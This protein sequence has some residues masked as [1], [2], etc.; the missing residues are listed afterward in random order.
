MYNEITFFGSDWQAIKLVAAFNQSIDEGLYPHMDFSQSTYIN[1]DTSLKV[2]CTKHNQY[3]RSELRHIRSGKRTGCRQ[4][5]IEKR[6]ERIANDYEQRCL[7]MSAWIPLE[8]WVGGKTPIKHKC[9]CCGDVQTFLPITPLSSIKKCKGAISDKESKTWMGEDVKKLTQKQLNKS[10]K[11]KSARYIKKGK[12]DFDSFL[13]ENT[14]VTRV[15]KYKGMM[16]KCKFLCSVCNKTHKRRC[17]DLKDRVLPSTNS[18][19]CKLC[20]FMN[21]DPQAHYPVPTMLYY[22]KVGSLYKIGITIYDVETRYKDE[23]VDYEI[24]KTWSYKT[25]KKAYKKEQKIL[26]KYRKYRYYGEKIFKKSGNTE[27]FTHDVL[28]LDNG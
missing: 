13:K 6:K 20:N 26:R 2:R 10:R 23:K 5:G 27:V 12:H 18:K 19:G 17:G 16:G 7:S 14:T 11:K 15:S 28:G 25:G 24:I 22:I 9:L 3:F 21:N 1:K 4:C 8:K